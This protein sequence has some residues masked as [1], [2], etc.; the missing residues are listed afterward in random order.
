LDIISLKR[1]IKKYV[2]LA[3]ISLKRKC[4]KCTNHH[5]T[6]S[7]YCIIISYKFIIKNL[8]TFLKTFINSYKFI[9]K[10]DLI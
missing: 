10:I 9:I 4:Y 5:V 3:K 8:Q 6:P 1:N 7:Y 2:F